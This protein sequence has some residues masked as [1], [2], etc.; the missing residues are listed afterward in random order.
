MKGSVF[1]ASARLFT[2]FLA[3]AT[4][5]LASPEFLSVKASD[6]RVLNVDVRAALCC[7]VS[8]LNAFS[9]TALLAFSLPG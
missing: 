1:A 5:C 9:A 3:R 4:Q 2:R 7:V 8:Y 6:S